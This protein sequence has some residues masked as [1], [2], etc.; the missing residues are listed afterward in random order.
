MR[1]LFTQSVILSLGCVALTADAFQIKAPFVTHTGGSAL[2]MSS[3]IP[4]KTTKAASL[5]EVDDPLTV[6][7]VPKMAQ[8]WRKKTKQ[9]ATLGPASSTKEMI[10]TLFLAG[11]DVF[12][13]NFSHGR[14]EQKLE[15]LK[16]IREVEEKYAHP[17]A[18]LG[19]LQGP[20][21]RVGEFSNPEGELLEQGQTFRF[22]LDE[23]KG[24]K[25]RVMLPHPEIIQASEV[26][27]VLLIDDGKVK[28][29]VTG[30]GDG[31]IECEVVVP[32]KIKDRKGVNT[33]DSI[34]EIS[35]LTPKDRSDLEY[36]LKIGVDW[37]ALS[38]VQ[39]PQDIVEINQLIDEKL[40][41]D[42]FRPAVMAKIEKPSCFFGD[43]LKEIVKLCD[44]IMVARGDLGVECAPEDVPI[45]QKTIIDECRDQGKPVVVATQM[46]E[47]MI[48]SP[49]PTR[50][51]ASDVATAIYDGA[52]AIMLSAES[53]AGKYPEESVIMQQ[54]I[55]NRVE[56]DRH[57]KLF[58]ESKVK[59]S[60]HQ[61]PTDAIILAARNIATSIQAK[62]VVCF[63]L[64]GTTV[65]RASK[66]R[67]GVPILAITPFKETARQLSLSWGVYPELPKAGSYGYLV[68]E[69]EL[70]DYDSPVLEEASDDFDM[71][72]R[73]ACRAALRKGLV[74][75]PDDLLVVTAGLPFGTPG[76]ANVIRVIPAAGPSC[77]DGVCRVD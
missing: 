4:Q 13:L 43:N 64:R 71:V 51:E 63:T 58:L 77:W 44:G 35:P 73:N 70:F 66:G 55:I 9:L 5:D 67:P 76:A 38:F 53:A 65:L 1:L 28:L 29:Q 60:E 49:T 54:R 69:E 56:G 18:V 48:E 8:R 14:Q 59:E 33:P 19:D 11:A 3:T 27:H 34:L 42:A 17:I 30:K 50:A 39:R 6:A 72:L 16:L 12:R 52:D 15:L 23:A 62:A 61:G 46:L 74:S 22:D 47:S 57:Y 68:D 21:L 41:P 25:N 45:L 7:A 36:M 40:P 10:E 37:V 26:G 32:G 24:D 2:Y 75:S 20:K 31:Y